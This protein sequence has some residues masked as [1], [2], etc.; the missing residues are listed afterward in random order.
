MQEVW[1]PVTEFPDFYQV[2]NLG[3]VCS[4]RNYKILK[5][6]VVAGYFRVR[7][8]VKGTVY[9]CLVHRLVCAAF[10]GAATPDLVV[11]HKNG[12]KQDNAPSNLEWCTRTE[13]SL[14]AYHVLGAFPHLARPG[15]LHV[16]SKLSNAEAR[17][18]K[19]ALREGERVTVVARKFHVSHSLISMIKSGKVRNN[20]ED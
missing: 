11:N 13:N 14:H 6:D 5:P 3:R 15:E 7:L 2:S 16:N 10:H 19:Q 17:A 12:N 9:R 8:T 20:Q 18:I 1:K 4:L